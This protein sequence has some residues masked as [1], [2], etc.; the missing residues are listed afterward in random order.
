MRLSRSKVVGQ[1]I[2][3]VR[4]AAS[5]SPGDMGGGGSI[6]YSRTAILLAN[7]V[8]I[9]LELHE[10]PLLWLGWPATLT[11]DIELESRLS[12]VIGCEVKGVYASDFYPCLVVLIEGDRLIGMNSPA[13]W[14]VVPT[15]EPIKKEDLPDLRDFFTSEENQTA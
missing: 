14:C 8:G 6:S 10:P 13:P 1:K 9:D 11:R 12:D 7:D 15:I 3:A 2:Q 5:Q 4:C